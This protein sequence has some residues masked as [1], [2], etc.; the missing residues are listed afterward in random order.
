MNLAPRLV[1]RPSIPRADTADT[2]NCSAR[3]SDQTGVGLVERVTVLTRCLLGVS[4]HDAR[5]SQDI[6]AVGDRLKVLRIDA[7]MIAAEVIDLE[8]LR[9]ESASQEEG[10]LMRHPIPSVNGEQAVPSPDQRSQKQPAPTVRFWHRQCGKSVAHGAT[11]PCPP[12]PRC[13]RPRAGPRTAAGRC[14]C[15]QRRERGP[16]PPPWSSAELPQTARRSAC[17]PGSPAP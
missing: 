17:I 15:R 6:H 16:A 7:G 10:S 4:S 3:V 12:H 14:G 5:P 11:H 13:L 2:A 1:G 8:S 9:D